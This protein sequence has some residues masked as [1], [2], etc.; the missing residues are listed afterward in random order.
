METG[1]ISAN[2]GAGDTYAGGGGG[3][4]IALFSCDVLMPLEQI[5]AT[6]ATGYNVGEDGTIFLGSGTV[7]I[8][9]QP[10]EQ[11]VALDG[12][13]TFSVAATGDGTLSYQWRRYGVDLVDDERI[14]GA[15]TPN[16]TI[17][18]IELCD[19]GSYYVVVTD[20][21]GGFP[22]NF[23]PLYVW[24]SGDL[25][26][27]ADVDLADLAQ[28]LSGYGI[29]SGATWEQGDLSGDG[30]VDLSDLAALLGVYGTVC[31]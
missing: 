16:L 19:A 21:C 5:T 11:V 27:D 14:S 12:T 1:T 18:M 10:V 7:E 9:T 4:R 20:D 23:A 17:D 29:T 13:A 24:N 25:D 2:G 26:G 3:G 8:T 22:S 6:G 31:E 28:L 30:D 15:T